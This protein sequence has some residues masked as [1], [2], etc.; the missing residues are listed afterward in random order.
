MKKGVSEYKQLSTQGNDSGA[1]DSFHFISR[2]RTTHDE[3]MYTVEIG[4]KKV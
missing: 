1:T 4:V 2:I 3:I